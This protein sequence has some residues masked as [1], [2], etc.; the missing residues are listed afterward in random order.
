[1]KGE[2]LGVNTVIY[3]RSGGSNG[4]GFAIPAAMVRRVVE[5]AISDGEVI[6]PWFGAR[7]QN[8]DRDLS[9]SLGMDR[10]QGALVSEVYRNSSADKAGIKRGDVVLSVD[11]QEINSNQGL[12]FRLAIHKVGERVPVTIFRDGREL[13]KTL[14]TRAA[15]EKPARDLTEITGSNPFTGVK[16][17][18]LSPALALEKELDPF[19]TGVIVLEVQNRS[20][21]AYYGVRPGDIVLDVDEH[22]I[23]D[24]SDLTRQLA[25]SEGRSRW[26]IRILRGEREITATIRMRR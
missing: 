23:E 17:A 18:N 8:V 5:S 21:A 24:V 25:N 2:L 11:G 15:P 14:K 1:M 20:A 7:L 4:I 13:S 16:V 22:S 19:L 26:P 12:R 3:S 6:R 9:E 10:P